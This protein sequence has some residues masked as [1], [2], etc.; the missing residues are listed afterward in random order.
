MKRLAAALLFTGMAMTSGVQAE[1][2]NLKNSKV[3]W[4]G[5]KVVGSTHTGEVQIQSADIKFKSGE[6]ASAKIV[7]DM[8]SITNSDVK[9][10]KWNKKLVDHL[11][12]DDFF[13]TNKF[14]TSEIH[15]EKIHK[16]D[17]KNYLLHGKLKIKDVTKPVKLKAVVASE[18]KSSKTIKVNFKFDR[19]EFGIKYGSGSFFTGLGDKMISDEVEI[20]VTLDVLKSEKFASK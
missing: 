14:K 11:K 8:T 19:T 18:N 9:D 2:V 16:A 20:G 13:G 10:P 12:D 15:I 4:T 17:G 7:I 1:T 3:E 5:A 6:P